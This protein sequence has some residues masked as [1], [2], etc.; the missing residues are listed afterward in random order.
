MSETYPHNL[1][2][3]VLGTG[4]FYFSTGATSAAQAQ[5]FGYRSVGNV[6]VL[7]PKPTI[8]KY[9]HEG[10]YRGKRIIDK[11]YAVKA[12]L[13]YSVEA[14]EMSRQ[15]LVLALGGN[16]TLEFTQPARTAA[17][18]DIITG[19]AKLWYDLQIGGVT[20]R[21]VSAVTLLSPATGTAVTADA[22]TDKITLASHNFTAGTRVVFGGTTVPTGL[23]AATAY[24]VVSPSTNDF[25][26]SA[27]A[28]GSPIDL[29]SA[30]SSVTVSRVL[31]P[32]TDYLF[33]GK[34]GKIRFQHHL[35]DNQ[36]ILP[37]ITARAVA[38]D[39]D[40]SAMFGL[41]PLQNL[42]TTGFAKI[43]IFDDT[44]PNKMVYYHEAFGC[45]VFLD[46]LEASDGKKT[47]SIKLT[48]RVDPNNLGTIWTAEDH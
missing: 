7:A 45:Q 44:A 41:T 42:V 43:A 31:E 6:N 26:V 3:L 9:D 47:G 20:V 28:G 39:I 2:A 21:E 23:A 8:D 48:V 13:E 17:N 30:G 5:S 4:E 37:L 34:M 46:S 40:Y 27:T 32:D 18:G 1:D 16:P 14:D 35:Y 19:Q 11:T 25:K 12:L 33:D 29:T 24:Y 15:N 10:S 36:P 22:S 38:Q